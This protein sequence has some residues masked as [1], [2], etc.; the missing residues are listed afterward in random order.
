MDT[1]TDDPNSNYNPSTYRFTPT[2]AGYYEITAAVNF[3]NLAA[4]KTGYT[5]IY[6]NG[7][8]VTVGSGQSSGA[9]STFAPV[10]DLLYAN[11]STDYFELYCLHDD[12][13]ARSISGNNNYP[14]YAKLARPD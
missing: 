1:E 14:W 10:H 11:G 3:I 9:T 5:Y 12:T 13:A 8:L 2:V 7:A 4:G 6:K